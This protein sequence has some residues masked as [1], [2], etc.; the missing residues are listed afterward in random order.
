MTVHQCETCFKEFPRS[1]HLKQHLARKT[2]CTAPQTEETNASPLSTCDVCG[3]QFTFETNM[4]RH[5]AKCQGPKKTVESLEK[6]VD[7]LQKQ[8]ETMSRRASSSSQIVNDYS[9]TNNITTNMNT[10][11]ININLNSYGH[12][13]QNHLENLSYPDL[14][15]ILKLTPDHQSMI[16]MIA[17]IYLNDNVPENRTIRLDDKTSPVINVF[18]RGR[19]REQNADTVLYDMICR[20]RLRFVDLEGTLQQGMA[21][22]KFDELTQYLCKAEDMANTEDSSLHLEYA[23]HDLMSQIREKIAT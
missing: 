22:G 5:R 14:K 21:K 20:N 4:Y 10:T 18:K 11:Q 3:K 15:R 23:F 17:F 8:I 6:K 9:T 19:W 16:R 13:S 12:E 7:D 2:P 1:A